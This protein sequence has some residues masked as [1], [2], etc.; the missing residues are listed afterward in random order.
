MARLVIDLPDGASYTGEMYLMPTHIPVFVDG[1]R[2]YID[3]S[4]YADLELAREFFSPHFGPICVMGPSLPVAS[5]EGV[6]LHEVEPEDGIQAVASTDARTRARAWWRHGARRWRADLEA[7]LPR[8]RVVHAS[9]DDVLRP[10]QLTGLRL[11]IARGKPTVLVG[12][13]MDRWE[14]LRSRFAGL[15]SKDKVL[16]LVRDSSMDLAMRWA[17]RSAHVTMLKEGVVFDRYAAGA[18]NPKAFCHSMHRAADVIEADQLE[19]R[20]RSRASGRPL[21]LGYFGRFIARKGLLDAIEIVAAARG[22][23][24]DVRYT[25]IGWGEQKPEL[26]GRIE[27]LGMSEHIRLS[28]GVPYGPALHERLR[29]LDGLLFAP[30]EED[31]PRMVYDAYAAGLPLLTSDIPFL[32]RRARSDGCSV[33]F[34]VGDVSGGVA[35]L[36]S[37]AGS[38][39]RLSELSRAARVQ[40]ERHSVEAWYGR[41]LDWTLEAVAGG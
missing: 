31:T 5:A 32:Q 30:I 18:K 25:L 35:A 37:V 29:A 15:S 19:S 23:G 12:F 9:V 11:A 28:D 24:L 7:L 22:K 4:W 27:A 17:A 34:G 3:N 39:D 2:R 41:R 1:D 33:L 14:V 38:Q 10:M 36:E 16:S 40:G 21:E 6:H 8:A 20:L 26:Q 13:D